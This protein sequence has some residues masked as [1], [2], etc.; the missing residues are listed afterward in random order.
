M[1]HEPERAPAQEAGQTAASEEAAAETAVEGPSPQEQMDALQDQL[2]QKDAQLKEQADRL[3]RAQADFQN[4]VKRKEKE[5]AEVFTMI[6]DRLLK[7]I[8]PLYDDLQ[9]AFDALEQDGKHEPFVEGMKRIFT[10]FKDYVDS[11]K[12]Q[13]IEAVGN[14][15]DPAWHEVLMAVESDQTPHVILEEFE[16]GY[17]R[18]G[19]L[20]R[21]SRVT[22][23][24]PKAQ[25]TA[26]QAAA[27][28]DSKGK[29]Q[30]E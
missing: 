9:R 10:K 19:R 26:E 5:Q 14:K 16:R 21:P 24:K 22:V 23:S 28:N 25:P 29:Q 17:R 1:T 20:L 6:E 7:E 12:I 2:Q 15:Y 11:K 8:L 18:E 27:D 30:K 13:P 4:Y 3:K